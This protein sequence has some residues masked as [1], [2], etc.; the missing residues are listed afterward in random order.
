M[1]PDCGMG[2]E[3]STISV[4]VSIYDASGNLIKDGRISY[5]ITHRR[6]GWVKQDHE[7]RG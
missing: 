6:P 2:I 7:R 4:R 3:I 1:I 5:V